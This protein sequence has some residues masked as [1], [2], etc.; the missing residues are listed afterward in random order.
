MLLEYLDKFYYKLIS[1]FEKIKDKWYLI[2]TI[3]NLLNNNLNR[4]FILNPNNSSIIN[5]IYR[6][7][8]LW[9]NQNIKDINYFLNIFEK[10]VEV[11]L[12]EWINSINLEMNKWDKILNTEI[13]LTNFDNNPYS[14]LEAH[15]EHI[16]YWAISWNQWEKTQKEWLCVYTKIF[17]LL[18]KVDEWFYDELNLIIKKIV[19]LGT[20]IW[21]HNSASYKECIW[22]LYM[23]YTIDTF[24]PEVNN[25]E[26]IIHEYSHNKLNLIL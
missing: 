1:D 3:S 2:K 20:S 13:K 26:A 9:Y 5:Y 10:Q 23:W 16:E 17:E 14:W 11:F 6:E 8:I 25:L 4:N 22:H 19:P 12:E 15:P 21:V 24:I 7:I 18:K